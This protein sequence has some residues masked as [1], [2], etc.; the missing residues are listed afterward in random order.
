LASVEGTGHVD[1]VQSP[2][3]VAEVV[4]WLDAIYGVERGAPA[5]LLDER[6]QAVGIGLLAFLLVAPGIGGLLGRLS[7]H[8]AE[9]PA[10]GA[11][12]R[13]LIVG[14]VLLLTLPLV[15]VGDPGVLLG[16]AVADSVVAQVFYAGLILLA[17]LALGN[18]LDLGVRAGRWDLALAA[19][20]VGVVVIYA[21]SIPLSVASHRLN[22]TPERAFL[23]VLTALG[24]LP[25][26][27]ASNTFLRRGSAWMS[28]ATVLLGRAVWIVILAVGALLG[29]IHGV[30]LLMLPILA[31]FFVLFEFVALPV[32]AVS[33]NVV[34]VA[35]LEAL[36]LAWIFAAVLPVTL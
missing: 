35:L 26:A 11:L 9:R 27:L 34:T 14:A 29:I 15:G 21:L 3:A 7:P 28:T 23:A 1:I 4:A 5:P 31:G 32:Y 12:G 24:L 22:L 30:V 8:V 36:W 2:G 16:L 10:S 25:F 17:A 33:R 6:Q 18:H 20:A 13:L 19:A